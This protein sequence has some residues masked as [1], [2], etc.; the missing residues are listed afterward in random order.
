MINI[1]F[2]DIQAYHH[3]ITTLV[4]TAFLS[5][6]YFEP[7]TSE[8]TCDESTSI[9][10][11]SKSSKS[12]ISTTLTQASKL[13]V[14]SFNN[15]TTFTN[16]IKVRQ[17]FKDNILESPDVQ[18]VITDSAEYV[19]GSQH[20]PNA[21]LRFPGDVKYAFIT[22]YRVK[23][24]SIIEYLRCIYEFTLKLRYFIN[25]DESN[26]EVN[27]THALSKSTSECKSNKRIVKFKKIKN[28]PM[29]TVNLKDQIRDSADSIDNDFRKLSYSSITSGLR[30]PMIYVITGEFLSKVL[31]NV[32][33]IIL[34]ATFSFACLIFFIQLDNGPI[35]FEEIVYRARRSVQFEYT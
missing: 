10:H 22:T 19:Q 11:N 16:S 17:G 30:D 13:N 9:S 25:E 20:S 7:L 14:K 6:A 15:S 29:H 8:G 27:S 23:N 24:I 3:L 18:G 12:I 26:I 21:L 32:I 33:I 5:Q 34:T 35:I 28:V 2:S 4:S 31:I 1:Q